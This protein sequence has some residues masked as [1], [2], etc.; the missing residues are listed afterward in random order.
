MLAEQSGGVISTIDAK[1]NGREIAAVIFF[2]SCR[3][4]DPGSGQV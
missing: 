1:K 4:Y 3:R 2:E